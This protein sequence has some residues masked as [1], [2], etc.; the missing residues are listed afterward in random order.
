[1]ALYMHANSVSAQL[2]MMLHR[3]LLVSDGASEPS[4]VIIVVVVFSVGAAWIVWVRWRVY[5]RIKCIIECLQVVREEF[6]MLILYIEYPAHFMSLKVQ[7]SSQGSTV[8]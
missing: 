7:A 1:M 2:E 6:L 5:S 3:V 4:L 8:W